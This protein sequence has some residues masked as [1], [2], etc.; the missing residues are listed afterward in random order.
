MNWLTANLPVLTFITS[1]LIAAI[2]IRSVQLRGLRQQWIKRKSDLYAEFWNCEFC[3]TARWWLMGGFDEIKP[4][5]E[6]RNKTE[7]GEDLTKC[8]NAKIEIL[9]KFISKL[10]TF[11]DYD[12]DFMNAK[13]EL[14]WERSFRLWIEK[15]GR[16]HELVKYTFECWPG[17]ELFHFRNTEFVDHSGKLKEQK[18]PT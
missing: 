5:L 6:K 17:L 18:L 11:K 13:K 12:G 14:I 10:A 4:I 8:E 16:H 15:M 9:D 3:A 2:S 7:H 1:V